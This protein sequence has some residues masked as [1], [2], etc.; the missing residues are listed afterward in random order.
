MAEMSSTGK[1]WKSDMMVRRTVNMSAS[2]M[3][4][5][6]SFSEM[7]ISVHKNARKVKVAAMDM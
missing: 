1:K 2:P 7:H 4:S 6:P 3:R 5:N